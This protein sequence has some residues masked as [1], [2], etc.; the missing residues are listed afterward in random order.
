[1]TSDRRLDRL[2]VVNRRRRAAGLDPIQADGA[3][4]MQ[5]V[6][7]LPATSRIARIILHNRALRRRLIADIEGNAELAGLNGAR[8]AALL[9]RMTGESECSELT[10]EQL[11]RVAGELRGRVSPHRPGRRPGDSSA[12]TAAAGGLGAPAAA[13]SRS[14]TP[15]EDT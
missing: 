6:G 14:S 13:S 1:M 15:K 8:L 11:R 9:V 4:S 12:G 5:R 7:V 2:D 10:L 3:S